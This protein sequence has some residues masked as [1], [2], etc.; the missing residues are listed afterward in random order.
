MSGTIGNPGTSVCAD[1][2][3]AVVAEPW[4]EIRGRQASRSLWPPPQS[5][6]HDSRHSVHAPSAACTLSDATPPCVL[7]VLDRCDLTRMTYE[8]RTSYIPIKTLFSATLEYLKIII[9]KVNN[10]HTW[11]KLQG[12]MFTF[13]KVQIFLLLNGL[14]SLPRECKISE[15]Y[16]LYGTY[17]SAT[18]IFWRWDYFDLH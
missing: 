18:K 4:A 1:A 7:P 5:S 12:L 14:P 17:W 8:S 13:L 10:I 2:A 15:V 9:T 3:A 16:I 11:I 6:P